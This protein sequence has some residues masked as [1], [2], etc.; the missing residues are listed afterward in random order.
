VILTGF[1]RKFDDAIVEYREAL[2]LNPHY[3]TSLLSPTCCFQN[4]SQSDGINMPT[5]VSIGA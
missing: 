3:V 2:R 1:E 5:N 4:R